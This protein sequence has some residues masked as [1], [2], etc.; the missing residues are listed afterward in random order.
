M[1]DAFWNTIVQDAG[2]RITEDTMLQ[3]WIDLWWQFHMAQLD[4]EFEGR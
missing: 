4:W 2:G 1:S 3:A